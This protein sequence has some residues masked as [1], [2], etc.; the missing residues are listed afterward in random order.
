MDPALFDRFAEVERT[1]W[2]FLARRRILLELVAQY[3]RPGESVLDIGCGTGF[4]LE[5]A[6]QRYK[7]CG[8]DPSPQAVAMCR[9]RGLDRVCQGSANDLSMIPEGCFAGA[10]LLD[11]LEHLDNDLEAL[12]RARDVLAPGGVVF[13]TVPAFKALWS[14]HDVVNQHRRRYTRQELDGLLHAAGFEVLRSSYFNTRLFP[15]AA[16]SRLA[17]R[18]LGWDPL[19]QLQ[20][21][22]PWLNRALCRVFEGERLRLSSP[23]PRAPY[24]F[25]LSILAVG[26][27]R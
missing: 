1:H 6:T 25:G 18:A 24:L 11:V 15:A 19:L 12:Q 2:W 13:V 26:R 3:L 21:P 8:V 22:A 23:N 10:F 14:R 20:V 27:R 7:A 9:E 17:F 5:A 16:L 4:V